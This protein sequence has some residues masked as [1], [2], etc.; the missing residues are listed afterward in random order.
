[1]NGQRTTWVAMAVTALGCSAQDAATVRSP[2]ATLGDLRVF[3]LGAPA[4]AAPDVG[5]LYFTLVN[6]GAKP[7]TL[8]TV[9]T[10]DGTAML[11]TVVTEGDFSRMRHVVMLPVGAGDTVRLRPGGYHIMVSN[12]ERQWE[13]GDTVRF[14]LAFS[15]AGSLELAAPVHTYTEV[16]ERLERAERH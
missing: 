1:M 3:D 4:P 12:L 14:T 11:H 8:L 2:D 15:G 9:T 6:V 7:D 5:A 10:P 16:V 13:V